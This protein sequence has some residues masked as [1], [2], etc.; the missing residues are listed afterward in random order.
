MAASIAGFAALTMMLSDQALAH[1]LIGGAAALG[2][3]APGCVSYTM[4]AVVSS[5]AWRDQARGTP[6]WDLRLVIATLGCAGMSGLG[7]ANGGAEA[8]RWMWALAA[9]AG[10][11][12]AVENVARMARK[13]GPA[14]SVEARGGVAASRRAEGTS[15]RAAVRARTERWKATADTPWD[16]IVARARTKDPR[17]ADGRSAARWDQLAGATTKAVERALD[18]ATLEA[19]ARA[20]EREGRG[21]GVDEAEARALIQADQAFLEHHTQGARARWRHVER[22][23]RRRDLGWGALACAGTGVLGGIIAAGAEPSVQV[24]ATL[25]ALAGA[26]ALAVRARGWWLGRRVEPRGEDQAV[27][28]STSGVS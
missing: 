2:I 6:E 10:T 18:A 14:E 25:A 8:L 16:E 15:R 21:L 11:A 5:R 7:A 26:L 17:I 3:A 27:G 24:P 20:L 23:R 12:S 22:G 9:A 1:T 4:I 19:L 13:R 28:A